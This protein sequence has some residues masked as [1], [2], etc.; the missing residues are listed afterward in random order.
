M[1]AVPPAPR[2][3]TASSGALKE[4][5]QGAHTRVWTHEVTE[6]CAPDAGLRFEVTLRAVTEEVS[7]DSHVQQSP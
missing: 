7:E 1:E 3:L 6:Q 4:T 5:L 2:P